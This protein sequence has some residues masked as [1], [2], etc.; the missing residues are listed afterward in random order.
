MKENKQK[1]TFNPT[2]AFLEKDSANK[3][4]DKRLLIQNEAELETDLL[5]SNCQVH[6]AVLCVH[7]VYRLYLRPHTVLAGGT[8]PEPRVLFSRLTDASRGQAGPSCVQ[9]PE[10]Q[11]GRGRGR[12]RRGRVVKSTSTLSPPP[13]PQLK[14]PPT[15]ENCQ[16]LQHAHPCSKVTT[17]CFCEGPQNACPHKFP[18]PTPGGRARP[19]RTACTEIYAPTLL[20][21]LQRAMTEASTVCNL[22]TPTSF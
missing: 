9:T 2:F 14:F 3:A 4:G 7:S 22:H 19:G 6:K 1:W 15:R 5:T 16:P 21:K 13:P 10:A 17:R 18:N 12:L 11:A 8:Q 20:E